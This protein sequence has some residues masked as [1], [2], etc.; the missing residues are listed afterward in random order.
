MFLASISWRRKA[1][2]VRI[3]SLDPE[4][5]GE[6]AIGLVRNSRNRCPL[7]HLGFDHHAVLYLELKKHSD[8]VDSNLLIQG[9]RYG[10]RSQLEN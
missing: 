8:T 9:V 2:Y 10:N 6:R 7:N 1:Q 5:L 4:L 3:Q